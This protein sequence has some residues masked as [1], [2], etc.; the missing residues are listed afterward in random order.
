[1]IVAVLCTGTALALPIVRSAGSYR[2][3]R[4]EGSPGAAQAV[5]TVQTSSGPLT[6]LDRDFVKRVRLAGLWEIP[7]GRMA[8]A[9]GG[10]PEVWTA[11][12]HLIDGNSDLDRAVLDTARTLGLGVPDEP[13]DQQKAWL[14]QLDDAQ[15]AQ[16]DR[17]FANIVRNAHGQ[18][19]AVVAQVRAGTRNSAVR[20]LATT[21][22]STVLDHMTV[23]E[24]TGLVNFGDLSGPPTGTSGPSR[25]PDP[26]PNP[27]GNSAPSSNPSQIPNPSQN[28]SDSPSDSPTPQR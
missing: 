5:Q 16:F 8:V 4:A 15:G 19:F 10:T 26:S 6:P 21:A 7:A 20:D 23:L 25:N 13:S 27:T 11:G 18:V 9:K 14:K 17:L 2:T 12:R 3:A 22:N 1:M 24:E 28:P